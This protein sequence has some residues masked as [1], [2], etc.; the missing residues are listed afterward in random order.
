MILGP[1]GERIILWGLISRWTMPALWILLSSRA[2]WT[3]K[4]IRASSRK[5]ALV[6]NFLCK[7]PTLD[8]L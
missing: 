4:L 5:W 8:V 7:G 2:T 3:A 6:L 1:V